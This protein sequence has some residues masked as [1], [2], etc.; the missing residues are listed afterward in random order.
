M[1][2][3]MNNTGTAPKASE[4]MKSL[5]ITLHSLDS[6]RWLH[7]NNTPEENAII[8]Q[9]GL[10]VTGE[11]RFRTQDQIWDQIKDARVALDA[12]AGQP[13]F[14]VLEKRLKVLEAGGC[15]PNL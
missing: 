6:N 14:E 2:V 9:I 11:M 12:L 10:E 8:A 4:A 3:S 7:E 13:F 1:I 15:T 5:N